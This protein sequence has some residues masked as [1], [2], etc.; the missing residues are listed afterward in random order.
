MGNCKSRKKRNNSF[1]D[2]DIINDKNPTKV[3]NNGKEKKKKNNKSKDIDKGKDKKENKKN[4]SI[5][6]DRDN[7]IYEDIDNS[8]KTKK[9]SSKEESDEEENSIASEKRKEIEIKE[10]NHKSPEKEVISEYESERPS[11]KINIKPINNSTILIGLANIGATCYMNATLQCL[12]NTDKLTN[13]FLKEF[14]YDK[15][16]DTKKYQI[17]IM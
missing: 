7:D 3:Y 14:K 1:D 5:D 4:K 6:K 9:S 12:S 2:K 17:N 16:D 15:N 8:K 13:Y 10:L 11:I